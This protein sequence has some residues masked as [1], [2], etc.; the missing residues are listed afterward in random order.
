MKIESGIFG[1]AVSAL[2]SR[3]GAVGLVNTVQAVCEVSLSSFLQ[4]MR[5][6]K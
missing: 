2:P 1:I 6:G 3:P 5:G 4:F